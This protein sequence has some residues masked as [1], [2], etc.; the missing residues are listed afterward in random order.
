[1]PSIEF[2][3]SP[4]VLYWHQ[5]KQVAWIVRVFDLDQPFVVDA[6]VITRLA[7]RVLVKIGVETLHMWLQRRVNFTDLR[8]TYV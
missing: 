8:D 3:H 6:I 4:S 2:K 1:M 5:T 7:F